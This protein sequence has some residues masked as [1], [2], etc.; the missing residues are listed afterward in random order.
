MSFLESMPA[1]LSP[2]LEARVRSELAEGERLVWLSQPRLGLFMHQSVPYVLFGIP[3]AVGWVSFFVFWVR[4]QGMDTPFAILSVIFFTISIG[5]LG[6]PLW[7]YRKGQRT[8]YALTDRRAI[9]VQPVSFRI[10]MRSYTPDG[11]LSI[12]RRERRDGAGDL[13]FAEVRTED[14]VRREGFLAI[15]RVREVEDL[16]RKTLF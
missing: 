14:Q 11:L 7:F 13:I 10:E 2:E 9:V 12:S 4:D 3:W 1:E 5:L 8:C 15:D 6:S 16:L